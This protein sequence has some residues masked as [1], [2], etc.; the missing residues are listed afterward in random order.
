MPTLRFSGLAP[1]LFTREEHNPSLFEIKISVGAGDYLKGAGQLLISEK[2]LGM[3]YCRLLVVARS[4]QP[5]A[6][7]S[8]LNL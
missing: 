5:V 2:L 7:I 3:P 6:E 8:V 1:D 4:I